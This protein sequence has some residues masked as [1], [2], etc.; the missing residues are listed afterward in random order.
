[1]FSVAAQ[2]EISFSEGVVA[3]SLLALRMITITVILM[4]RYDDSG[5]V[6]HW[7]AT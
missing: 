1:M 4:N 7:Y 3:G 2:I 6:Q 5:G